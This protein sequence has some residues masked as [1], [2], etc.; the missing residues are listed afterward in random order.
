VFKVRVTQDAN[1][2]KTQ[3]KKL[4]ADL[5]QSKYCTAKIDVLTERC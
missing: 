3:C 5:D 2:M 1:R 4:F